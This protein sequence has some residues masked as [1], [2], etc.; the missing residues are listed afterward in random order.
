MQPGTGPHEATEH[1]EDKSQGSFIP[2]LCAFK[3]ISCEVIIIYIFFL[4]SS[5]CL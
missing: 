3:Q 1:L 5:L 4:S 2:P